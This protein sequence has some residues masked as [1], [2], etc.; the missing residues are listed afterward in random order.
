ML[1][2]GMLGG[3]M[4]GFWGALLAVL[5]VASVWDHVLQVRAMRRIC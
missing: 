1:L 4:I 5:M 3:E 2:F